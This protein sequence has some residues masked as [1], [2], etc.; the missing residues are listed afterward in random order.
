MTTDNSVVIARLER[1]NR[2]L[3]EALRD[4]STALRAEVEERRGSELDRRVDRDLAEANDADDLLANLD[5]EPAE[6]KDEPGWAIEDA[7]N[8]VCANL[9]DGCVVALCME[10]GAAWVELFD[11]QGDR[12]LLPDS[13]DKTL[14]EQLN[15]AVDMANESEAEQCE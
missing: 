7:A 14:I 6:H 5:S 8:K 12:R 1:Q 13:A 11:P 15:D 2:E 9:P 10:E 4:C 3:A